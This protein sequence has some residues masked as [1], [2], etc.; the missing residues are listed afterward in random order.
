MTRIYIYCQAVT[1]LVSVV[2]VAAAKEDV[3]VKKTSLG[4]V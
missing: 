3:T 1:P 2:I 4:G